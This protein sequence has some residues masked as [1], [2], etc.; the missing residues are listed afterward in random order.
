[1][2][3]P[4]GN[5]SA[6]EWGK[7]FPCLIECGGVGVDFSTLGQIVAPLLEWYEKNKRSLPWR[8]NQEPYRVWISEI[9]LQQTRVEAVIP[10]YH[11]FMERFPTIAAL[12]E[13]QE[14]ELLKYWEGLGYYSRA[15][16]L[17]KAAQLICKDYQGQFPETFEEIRKLPGIGTY[18]AGAISSIAFGK[19][20]A[21]VDGN[22][23]RVVTR[24]T[25]KDQDIMEAAFRKEVTK[26]LEQIYPKEACAAFTQSIMELGAV[27]CVPNGNPK[28]VECPLALLCG[29]YRN[30]TQRRYPVKRKKAERKIENKTVLLLKYQDKIAIRKRGTKG[31]LAGM[32]ELPNLE[33][34]QTDAE[35]CQWLAEQGISLQ[36]AQNVLDNRFLA[37][38][39]FTHIEWRMECIAAECKLVS[40][41]N[42]FIWVTQAQLANEIALPSAFKKVYQKGV[43]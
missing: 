36:I 20:Y 10:Y 32:W 13:S 40:D 30:K 41:E 18:T 9:M 42:T 39:I 14:E 23:L 4:R 6:R 25:E 2:W 34:H 17:R 33:G 31:V 22:V 43:L 37:K 26:A 16:N 1:M 29:A 3:I 28:C 11:R 5:I 7:G 15:K 12:A 19:A 38:H 35:V 27:V 21:A 8:E 24:L